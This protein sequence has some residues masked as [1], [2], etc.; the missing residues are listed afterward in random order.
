MINKK[1]YKKYKRLLDMLKK[2][3]DALED[4]RIHN[5]KERE[6]YILRSLEDKK[7]KYD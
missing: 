1:I 6:K 2:E 7:D 3:N 5:M 4:R